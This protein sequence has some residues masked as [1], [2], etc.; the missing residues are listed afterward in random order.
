MAAQNDA[1]RQAS[2]ASGEDVGLIV[3]AKQKISD[4]AIEP[5]KNHYRDRAKNWRSQ[6]N[7]KHGNYGGRQR[8]Q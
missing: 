7:G 3:R 6:V 4:V 2:R 8:Q 1:A 5:W